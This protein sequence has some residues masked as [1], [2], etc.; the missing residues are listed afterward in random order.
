MNKHTFNSYWLTI[1]TLKMSDDISQFPE[2]VRVEPTTCQ[3]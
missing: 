2:E 1:P 3:A